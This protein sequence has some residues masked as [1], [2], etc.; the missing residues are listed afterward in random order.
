[1]ISPGLTHLIAGSVDLWT[2]CHPFCSEPYP[3]SLATTSLLSVSRRWFLYFVLDSML[4]EIIQYLSFSV[5]LISW[6]IWLSMMPSEFIDVVA[7]RLTFFYGWTILYCSHGIDLNWFLFLC[8]KRAC[9]RLLLQC[10]PWLNVLTVSDS[11]LA[12]CLQFL[13]FT[14]TS[15]SVGMT[16][17][18]LSPAIT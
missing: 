16:W 8:R 6:C 15:S 11:F 17:P 3:L 1:M 13:S 4:S 12:D 18:P 5:W 9:Y 7:G 2:A 14:L 10:V